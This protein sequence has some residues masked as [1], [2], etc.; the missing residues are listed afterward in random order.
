MT[1]YANW[2]VRK[3]QIG[4]RPGVHALPSAGTAPNERWPTD[5]CRV[6]AGRDG[7]ATLALLI[8]CHTWKLL[9]WRL[10]RS[11]RASRASSA[12]EHTRIAWCGPLGRMPKPLLLRSD[13][14]L[15]FTSRDHTALVRSY[16]LRQK[17]ITPHRPQQN[18][19][20]ER[21][22]RSL[23]EQCVHRPRF[24]TLQHA[25]LAIADWIQF[26]NHPRPH[27]PLKTKAPAEAFALAAS[28][29]Q[30]SL[31]HYP[32]GQLAPDRLR[33]LHQPQTGQP[34]NLRIVCSKG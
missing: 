33:Q 14:G 31:G 25:T 23:K 17:F 5:M 13:N 20:V 18:G 26:Y 8:D 3:R 6:W 11:G 30:V 27:Q 24:E 16:G 34:T 22:L 12:L 21:V 4:F 9:G 15:V 7:W 28:P 29:V 2:Q 32:L 19:M 10:S 1:R